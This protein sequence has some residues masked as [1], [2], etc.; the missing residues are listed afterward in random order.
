[1]REESSPWTCPSLVTSP[2]LILQEE[3]TFDEA[4]RSKAYTLDVEAF[5][6]KRPQL[7]AQRNIRGS[8]RPD[9]FTLRN[10]IDDKGKHPRLARG[11]S[12]H[13]TTGKTTGNTCSFGSLRIPAGTVLP[14]RVPPIE[15]PL[16]ELVGFGNLGESARATGETIVFNDVTYDLTARM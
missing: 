11:A 3:C 7:I 13:P 15:P 9:P 16:V 2:E 12:T 6:K 14:L 4:L 1:M 8:K 10:I 5:F